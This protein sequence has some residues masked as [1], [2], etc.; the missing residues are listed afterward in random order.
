[1]NSIAIKMASIMAAQTTRGPFLMVLLFVVVGTA[2]VAP[3][4]RAK[5]REEI[6]MKSA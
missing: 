2:C 1:M 6:I 3:N 5:T 4:A